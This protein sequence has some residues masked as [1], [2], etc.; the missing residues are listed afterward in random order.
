MGIFIDLSISKSITLMEWASVY[1][2][3]LTLAQKLQLAEYRNVEI[4]GVPIRC[5][6]VTQERSEYYGTW[7]KKLWTGFNID[8]DYAT[9]E[10]GEDNGL[11]KELGDASSDGEP[12][13]AML[14]T[15][16]SF[17]EGKKPQ[18]FYSLLGAKTQ[19]YAHHI[20]L[21]AV[22]CLIQDR[23]GDQAYVYGDINAGQCRRAVKLANEHLERPISVPDTCDPE[24]MLRRLQRLAL[25]DEKRLELL[26]WAYLGKKDAAFGDAMRRV[27][28]EAECYRMWEERFQD[29]PTGTRGFQKQLTEYL[30]T[31]FDLERLCRFYPFQVDD[32]KDERRDF[33]QILLE[34]GL[35]DENP[36]KIHD[37]MAPDREE[38]YG[39]SALFAHFLG[40]AA[41]GQISCYLPP[42][43]CRALLKRCLDCPDIVDECFAAWQEENASAQTVEKDEPEAEKAEEAYDVTDDDELLGFCTGDRIQ[44]KLLESIQDY[45]RFYE[46]LSEET[47]YAELREKGVEACFRFLAAQCQL[48]SLRDRDW[49]RIWET[50]QQ[51][52]DS[53]T[54][55]YPAAR[56]RFTS[57]AVA[58]LVRAILVNDAFYALLRGEQSV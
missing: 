50:L 26:D 54:R 21:L 30:N 4:G 38:P 49:E 14:E 37:P 44:P 35:C 23:L 33:I 18:E 8:G 47:N 45:F 48:L 58:N 17:K 7:E 6:A 53:F 9:M 19:G 42:E 11:P 24:R 31:G 2:E 52:P 32:E 56:V 10:T 41:R 13:D 27:S 28:G 34:T 15:F 5:L 3:A 51:D 1:Q 20:P 55:Y 36:K 46:G 16:R 40:A 12:L 22:C 57:N 43:E 25:P 39:V 29:C